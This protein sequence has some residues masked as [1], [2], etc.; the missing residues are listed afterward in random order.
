LQAV[1][2]NFAVDSTGFSTSQFDR[3]FNIRIGKDSDKRRCRKVHAMCGTKTNVI[4]SVNVTKGTAADCPEFENLVRTTNII[5]DIKE[6]SADKAYLSRK[7]LDIV[8]QIGGIAYIPFKVNSRGRPKG[9]WIWR[10]MYEYYLN[11]RQEFMMHYHRRSNSETVF[12]MLKMKF[13]DYL[14]SRHETSQENEILAKCLIH[15]LCV[16]IQESF[17]LGID[18]DFKKCAELYFAQVED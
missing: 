17:E 18:L 8:S 4:T 11:N 3:W 10:R 16:L 15:N 12:H 13:S 1:E 5:Y 14:R 7:N 2:E 6:V 9:P